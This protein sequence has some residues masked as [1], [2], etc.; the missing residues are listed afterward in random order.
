VNWGV[1][2][3]DPKLMGRGPVPATKV[4]LQRAGLTL[5]YIDLMKSMRRLRAILAVEQELDWTQQVNVNAEDCAG[6]SSGR[7]RG[8]LGDYAAV[9]TAAAEEKYGLANGLIGGGQ[10]ICDGGGDFQ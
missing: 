8:A 9:R 4:A 1:A 3:V 5:D 7:D 6:T 10:G 2:G